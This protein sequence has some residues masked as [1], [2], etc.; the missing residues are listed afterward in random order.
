MGS[1]GCTW[2][3]AY[4]I[5]AKTPYQAASPARIADEMEECIDRFHIREVNFLEPIFN[6][7]KDR[8]ASVA[9]EFLRRGLDFVWSVKVRADQMD[10]GSARLMAR[11]GCV[12]VHV[13]IESGN[14]ETLAL[15][16]RTVDID[17]VRRAVDVCHGAGMFVLGYYQVGYDGEKPEAARDSIDLARSLDLDFI[18]VGATLPLPGSEVHRA[19]LR[20]GK[21]DPWLHFLRKDPVGTDNFLVNNPGRSREELEALKTRFLCRFFLRPE[22]LG[23][24]AKLSEARRLAGTLWALARMNLSAAVVRTFSPESASAA[25][26]SQTR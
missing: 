16:K 2:R 8:A 10:A 17:A 7:S 3:C 15:M 24:V 18:E 14:A 26:G 12:R 5:D 22:Y 21:P 11:A 25:G 9:E 4:C 23:R 1:V 13:G 20:A 19:L 6:I